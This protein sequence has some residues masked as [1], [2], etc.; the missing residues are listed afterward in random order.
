M[1][2]ILA[3][4]STYQRHIANDICLFTHYFC[5]NFVVYLKKKKVFTSEKI[6]MNFHEKYSSNIDIHSTLIFFFLSAKIFVIIRLFFF[7]DSKN[8]S[9]DYLARNPQNCVH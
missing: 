6:S 4:F 2:T 1:L 7:R 3:C 8:F 9:T 5:Y